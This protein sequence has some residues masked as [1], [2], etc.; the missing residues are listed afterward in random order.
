MAGTATASTLDL[1]FPA[2][3]KVDS[4]AG[5]P[6]GAA[7]IAA[8]PPPSRLTPSSP[9]PQSLAPR[10]VARPKAPTASWRATRRVIQTLTPTTTTPRRPSPSLVGYTPTESVGRRSILNVGRLERF[11]PRVRSRGLPP[12]R[13]LSKL[14][15]PCCLPCDVT[16][17]STAV[18]SSRSLFFSLDS[19]IVSP[20]RSALLPPPCLALC[21]RAQL[22]LCYV[23]C[24]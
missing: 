21:S 22:H 6:K 13:A 11:F 23:L 5:K 20:G 8:G 24:A 1:D 7:N 17:I 10:G 16:A 18:S 12:R 14:I 4:A 15:L 3:P 2:K 9:P 19:Y